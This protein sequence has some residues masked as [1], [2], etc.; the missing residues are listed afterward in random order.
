MFALCGPRSMHSR[1]PP[2]KSS[3]RDFFH[4]SKKFGPVWCF[5][6]GLASVLSAATPTTRSLL[7]GPHSE[8]KANLIAMIEGDIIQH[9]YGQ[10]QNAYI[11]WICTARR[12]GNL[13]LV[14]WY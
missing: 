14:A 8:E 4:F 6:G 13:Q 9:S 2:R 11:T 3:G 12:T 7:G 5:S 1:S 10:K